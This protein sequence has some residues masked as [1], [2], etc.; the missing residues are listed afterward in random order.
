MI[1]GTPPDPDKKEEVDLDNIVVSTPK[2]EE[3]EEVVL[4]GRVE[5]FKPDKGYGFIRNLS[6]TD[7]Y[8]F[9]VSNAQASIAEGNTVTFELERGEKGMNA[10]KITL[11]K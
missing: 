3:M 9:H 5:H 10:I 4:S 11:T 2:R 8:F 1:T 6:G 7:K